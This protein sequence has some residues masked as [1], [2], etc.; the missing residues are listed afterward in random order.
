[1]IF[2]L[3]NGRYDLGVVGR[4]K[5][6]KRL[7]DVA[8]FVPS[9]EHVLTI[10]DIIATLSY[11]MMLDQGQGDVDDIDSLSNRR[12]RSVGEL[13]AIN[14]FRVGMLR[15]ERSIK[16]RMSLLQADVPIT[17]A[18]LINA[19]PIM[20][21]INEFFRTSQLSTILDQT[22][23]LSEIDNLNR[24]TVMGT[25]GISRERAAFSIR[26]INSSQYGRICPIRSPEG[27]NIGLVTYFALYSRIN[28]YGFIES[29][30]RKVSKEQHGKKSVIR[31]TDELVYMAADDEREHHITHDGIDISDSGEILSER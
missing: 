30:Y 22:N 9:K 18:N 17:V 14:A 29:P 21:S 12:I 4:Y 3:N 8:G 25:G 28:D 10:E 31:I 26:D 20:A 2:F 16:E 24:L 7:K 6:N 19:R 15:V 13:V 5:T 1:M 11:L 23:P 27:P